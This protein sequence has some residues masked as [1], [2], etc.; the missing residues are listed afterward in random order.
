MNQNSKF[1]M[2]QSKLKLIIDCSKNSGRISP[3]V[4]EQVDALIKLGVRCE[5]F[6]IENKG[7]KGYLKSRNF[8]LNKIREF[9]PDLIHAHFGLSGLLANLQTKVPVIT[10]FHGCDI[11]KLSL[12]ILSYFPLIFSKY[13]IFVSANQAAKVP[14]FKSKSSILPCGNSGLT[15]P[16]CVTWC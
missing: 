2:E 12:R 1:E 16:R 5:Y 8:L 14:F 15:R 13:C 7:W 11:N 4:S 6:T 3:F 9:N 10:T